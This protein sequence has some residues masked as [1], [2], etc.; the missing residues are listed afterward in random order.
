M[1]KTFDSA[2]A[3]KAQADLCK[4]K[5]YPHFA[6][7]SGVCWNCKK[8]IYQ[9]IDRGTYKTGISVEQATE[10]LITGCPHCNRSYCD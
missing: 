3:R 10:S 8:D 9:Q 2:K 5:N 6:P 7:L 1:E 4:E